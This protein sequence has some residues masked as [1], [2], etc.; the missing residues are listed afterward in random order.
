MFYFDNFEV[1]HHLTGIRRCGKSF[2]SL[3]IV[4]ENNP[5]KG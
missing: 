3:Q 1:V 5:C 4:Q 2:S